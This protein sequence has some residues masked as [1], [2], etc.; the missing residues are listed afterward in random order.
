MSSTA[1]RTR[2]VLRRPRRPRRAGSSAVRPPVRVRPLDVVVFVVSVLAVAAVSVAAYSRARGTPEAHVRGEQ[3][4]WI[5]PLEGTRTL[6][7]SG[8]LGDTIVEIG[9]GTVRVVSS[10]CP[11]QTCVRAG[12]LSTAGQWVAC[13]PNKVFVTLEGRAREGL[14][15]VSQ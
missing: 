12:R 7:V 14:D 3:G 8:P 11:E 1:R 5:Y 13:L 4:E 6:T 15:A 2:A 9:D 10:P